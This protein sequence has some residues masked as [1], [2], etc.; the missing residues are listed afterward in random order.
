[1]LQ[2]FL[3]MLRSLISQLPIAIYKSLSE[4]SPEEFEER[5]QVSM[6]FLFKTEPTGPR[7]NEIDWLLPPA[8]DISRFIA[9]ENLMRTAGSLEGL[10][11]L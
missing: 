5:V 10:G 1:M 2:M 8:T 9:D 6:G 7:E 11:Q 3:D 4:S